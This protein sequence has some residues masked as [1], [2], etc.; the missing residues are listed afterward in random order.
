MLAIRILW[1]LRGFRL[2]VLWKLLVF[3]QYGSR[4]RVQGRILLLHGSWDSQ[5][6]LL[7]WYTLCLP[8][9]CHG[10]SKNLKTA[11]VL[12]LLADLW[13][14]L[15]AKSSD[16]FCNGCRNGI[17]ISGLKIRVSPERQNGGFSKFKRLI[18]VS[19]RVLIG[20]QSCVFERRVIMVD[21]FLQFYL[22]NRRS[23][24]TMLGFTIL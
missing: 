1:R 13:F 24:C 22:I 19:L 3:N 21:G 17:L 4:R 2:T 14:T 5:G 18:P 16:F 20:C 12:T 15:L 11:H 8:K 6:C 23:Q 10:K 9:T 7:L